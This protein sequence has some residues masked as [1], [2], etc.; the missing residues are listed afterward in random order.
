[1]YLDHSETGH[2]AYDG[3]PYK[4]SRTPGKLSRPAPR[5]GEH[6]EYVCKENLNMNDEEFTELLV[7][8]V[9]EIG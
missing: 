1:M 9:L 6:T 3:I 8:E 2:S 4:L 5:L 7:E